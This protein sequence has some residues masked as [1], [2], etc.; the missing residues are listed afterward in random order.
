MNFCTAA[1]FIGMNVCENTTA[2]TSVVEKSFIEHLAMHGK[3]Y[4]TPEEYKFRLNLFAERE[5]AYAT[6][7]ADS[8][9]TFTVGH[10]KFSTYTKD[11]MKKMLGYKG[12]QPQT[13]VVVLPE[14]KDAE[15]DW[16]TDNIVNLGVR[17][18]GECGSSW[19]FGATAAVESAHAVDVGILFSLSEQ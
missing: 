16:R 4:G 6:I 2:V 15:V 14:A 18:Q 19:A 5:A 11:E 7:N 10:N 17:D 3:S 1:A 8:N 9:N 12:I 13:N